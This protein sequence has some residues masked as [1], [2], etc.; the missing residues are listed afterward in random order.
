M[1]GISPPPER[2]GQ[3]TQTKGGTMRV[4]KKATWLCIIVGI[5]LFNSP[6]ARG[7]F[8]GEIMVFARDSSSSGSPPPATSATLNGVENTP[9]GTNYLVT[10]SHYFEAGTN[11]VEVFTEAEGY[12]LRRSPTDSNA[13]NDPY[14]GYGNPR[15]IEI[16][17]SQ[18]YVPVSFMFDPVITASATVRDAWTMERIEGANIEFICKTSAG[19]NLVVCKYPETAVYATN[20]ITDSEGCFP[21]NTILYL[22]DYDLTLTRDGYQSYTE[23]NTI[24]NAAPGDDFDLG[25]IFMTPLDNN[26]N[27]IADVWEDSFFGEGVNVNPG[28]D[29]DGDGMS[30]YEEYIAGT[31][32]TNSQSCLEVSCYRNT[33]GLALTWGAEPS[34][35]YIVQGTTNICNSN[36]WV[37]VGGPWETTT[38]LYEMSWT[39]TNTDRSWNNSYRIGIVPSWYEGINQ[40]LINTN[41]V[42]SGSGTNTWNGGGSPPVPG[43]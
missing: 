32:P 25:S 19:E 31:N 43:S 40:V 21:S 16:S 20:W 2:L 12:L 1:W 28:A 11:L 35:T 26:T 6:K 38:N 14:S 34:R 22:D 15:Y 17:E 29:I 37:Q 7:D 41:N 30:N 5:S 33:E 3:C 36:A 10:F 39:E 24:S 9:F 42:Y 4:A 18:N 13:Q 8:P 27:F 23:T